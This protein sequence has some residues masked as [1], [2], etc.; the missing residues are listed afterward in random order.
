MAYERDAADGTAEGERVD[1]DAAVVGEGEDARGVAL[2]GEGVEG[3]GCDVEVRVG[4]AEGEEEEEDV[5]YL[6]HAGDASYVCCYDLEKGVS[7]LYRGKRLF[8]ICCYLEAGALEF[9]RKLWC[10]GGK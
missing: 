1:G 9:V 6:R 4:G 10:F 7:I 2:D 8:T 5:D 3:S